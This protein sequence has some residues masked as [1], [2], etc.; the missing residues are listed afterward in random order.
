MCCPNLWKFLSLLLAGLVVAGVFFGAQLLA[1]SNGSASSLAKQQES[2]ASEAT[3]QP[4]SSKKDVKNKEE[5]E[6]ELI[7]DLEQYLTN[8]KWVGS[9]SV[10]GQEKLTEE[11]YHIVS[12]EKDEEGDQW[13]LVAR[14]KYNNKDVKV[15]IGIEIKWA[16]ETPV[17]TAQDLTIPFM[18]TFNARVLINE[19]QYAGTWAHG[20]V[21]GHL[22]GTITK[23]EKE[24]AEETRRKKSPQPKKE[25]DADK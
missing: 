17:I 25:D 2:N 7:K 15:P 10:R 13:V 14:I 20:K 9:F 1:G 8:T 19:G 23:L 16:G 22:F 3:N 6:A 11:E 5:R 18:G 24:E 12:A 4:S 21:G